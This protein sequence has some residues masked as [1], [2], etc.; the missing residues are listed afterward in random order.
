[1]P[2]LAQAPLQALQ[3]QQ[4]LQLVTPPSVNVQ[5]PL[6]AQGQ[7][8]ALVPVPTQALESSAKPTLGGNVVLQALEAKTQ[9]RDA[10]LPGGAQPLPEGL[11]RPSSDGA[12]APLN[13]KPVAAAAATAAVLAPPAKK[14]KPTPPLAE[15]SDA[16][17]VA[18]RK[19]NSACRLASAKTGEVK[20]QQETIFSVSRLTKD[21]LQ[22]I[23]R[24][25]GL[26][27]ITGSKVS[28]PCRW[29]PA[30]AQQLVQNC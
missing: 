3:A 11:K 23:N 19:L 7:V 21:Q 12:A 10:A 6:Q 5:P 20:T 1:M 18:M 22:L 27:V 28:L 29:V 13:V 26:P 9:G 8:Q 24:H 17:V 2:S 30:G 25:F 4:A 16:L 14:L 15:R